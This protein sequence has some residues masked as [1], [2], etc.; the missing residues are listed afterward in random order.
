MTIYK[1]NAH[2]RIS[3]LEAEGRIEVWRVHNVSRALTYAEQTLV[4]VEILSHQFRPENA[5]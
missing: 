3:R 4:F 5:I 1:Y 2:D